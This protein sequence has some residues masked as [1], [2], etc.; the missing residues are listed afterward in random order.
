MYGYFREILEPDREATGDISGMISFWFTW[1]EVQKINVT[2]LRM[3]VLVPIL[4]WSSA[5]IS[6]ADPMKAFDG[7]CPKDLNL[8]RDSQFI[9]WNVKMLQAS[10][11]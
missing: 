4:L 2:E 10:W 7:R 9:Y 1:I 5:Y 3:A 11:W 6:L 8:L